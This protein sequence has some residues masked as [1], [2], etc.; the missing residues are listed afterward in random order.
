[1]KSPTKSLFNRR[2]AA[3]LRQVD[4]DPSHYRSGRWVLLAQGLILS[5]LGATGL[6]EGLARPGP[7]GPGGAAVLVLRLTPL[8][9]AVLVA[10]GLAALVAPLHRRA[11]NWVTGLSLI[12]AVLGFTI[13]VTAA[14]NGPS[15]LWG[16]D[17]GDAWLHG[18]VMIVD[19]ALLVWLLPDELQDPGWFW[20]RRR[21]R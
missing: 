15:G 2:Q 19:L 18:V 20:K 16:L 14:T 7:A 10:F 17:F 12:A 1:V 11:T 13:A 4:L 8:H 21:Q 6:V 9:S 3:L 5:A